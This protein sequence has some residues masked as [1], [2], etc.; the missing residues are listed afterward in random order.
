MAALALMQQVEAGLVDLEAPV[1]RYLPW[2]RTVDGW[3]VPGAPDWRMALGA[4]RYANTR[5]LP[6]AAVAERAS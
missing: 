4:V 5:R 6:P 3:V 1:M 2:F